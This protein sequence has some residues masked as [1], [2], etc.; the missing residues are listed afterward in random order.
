M[1]LRIGCSSFIR[2]KKTT[3][4]VSPFITA[5][6]S[7][8]SAAAAAA[9]VAPFSL[10]LCRRSRSSSGSSDVRSK[11]SV[12][13][14]PLFS[15]RNN[16]LYSSGPPSTP[17]T[18]VTNTASTS[19]SATST[20]ASASAS[21]TATATAAAAAAEEL[22]RAPFTKVNPGNKNNGV[23]PWR[24]SPFVLDR[25]VPGT[26]EYDTK[27]LLLANNL[28]SSNPTMDYYATS[29]FFLQIPLLDLLFYKSDSE[30]DLTTNFAAA[31]QQA[32]HAITASQSQ[33][34]KKNN[35]TP[36]NNKKDA[37]ASV[38]KTA[39]FS[40]EEFTA[41]RGGGKKIRRRR[42]LMS[43]GYHPPQ[44]WSPKRR[45]RRRRRRSR[46]FVT[47]GMQFLR[48]QHRR[49]KDT[50]PHVAAEESLA[51]TIH[52]MMEPTLAKLYEAAYE[53]GKDTLQVKL[54]VEPITL[55]TNSASSL[56]SS[57]NSGKEDV[58]DL[59]DIDEDDDDINDLGIDEPK[60]MSLFVLPYLSRDM[61][62]N[63]EQNPMNTSQVK[64]Y[65]RMIEL[66]END[67]NEEEDTGNDNGSNP[68]SSYNEGVEIGRS[69]ILDLKMNRQY[70][71]NTVI[72][73]VLLP[74]YETF[75][76]I[77]QHTNDI[78]QGSRR[79]RRKVVH[80]VRFEMVT[81]TY[82]IQNDIYNR[83]FPFETELGQWI[84]TD[85]DDVCN[86]NVLL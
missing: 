35:A 27:G 13:F 47:Q 25:F 60:L 34:N 79:Q 40:H 46:T 67:G 31:F 21:S 49:R 68:S 86:G 43:H 74:C 71:E 82:I 10:L 48:Q 42:R 41:V 19:T 36:T 66:I 69:M 81:K 77:D 78:V 37:A 30:R 7:L 1:L 54:E 5:S 65:Q 29:Y 62:T 38:K 2:K 32:V 70:I 64:K 44:A 61:I 55:A 84:I 15:V 3:T 75:C 17:T 53:F 23:F 76:V 4:V 11:Q 26:E 9:A 6:S 52:D 24:S 59:D 28:T 58:H 85:I 16:R 72:A 63:K 20:S 8:S 50:Y 45:R 51:P 80:L 83:W 39:T 18:P 56:L 12:G 33:T 14:T 22:L 73:Q 57:S